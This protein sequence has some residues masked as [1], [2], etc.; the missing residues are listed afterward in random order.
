[1]VEEDLF[2]DIQQSN[3]LSENITIP[4]QIILGEKGSLIKNKASYHSF[5]KTLT[6]YKTVESAAHTF[7][8]ESSVE[9]LLRYTLKWF[10][11]F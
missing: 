7:W 9:P 11:Q 2:Y 10:D 5:C 6:D 4:I 3:K 1:M 8:E